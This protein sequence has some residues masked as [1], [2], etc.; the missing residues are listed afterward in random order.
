MN[1]ITK[2]TRQLSF[3]DI[4]QKKKVRYEQIVNI[5]NNREMTAKEIAVEMHKRGLTDSSDRNYSQPR[6]CELVKMS[7]VEVVGKKKCE[8]T[9]K[10]VAVY[11]LKNNML[12]EI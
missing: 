6:L 11:K 8:F 2:E 3:D 1:D 5:L 4:N 10:K 12:N 9:N 7:I